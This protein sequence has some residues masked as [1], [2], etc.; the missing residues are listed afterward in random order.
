[1]AVVAV[2]P[3]VFFVAQGALAL[4][5]TAVL[6]ASTGQVVKAAEPGASHRSWCRPGTPRQGHAWA[7]LDL[8]LALPP[9]S[10]LEEEG[11]WCL[12]PAFLEFH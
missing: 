7:P 12:P 6:V 2:E 10:P 1:M 8:P 4:E 9:L 5:A 11:T 3:T